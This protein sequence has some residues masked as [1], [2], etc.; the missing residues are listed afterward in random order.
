MRFATIPLITS[1]RNFQ[2]LKRHLCY[3]MATR[4]LSST[5]VSATDSRTSVRR[6]IG[7]WLPAFEAT[8]QV[9]GVRLLDGALVTE[10]PAS[11]PLLLELVQS[12]LRSGEHGAVN[13]VRPRPIFRETVNAYSKNEVGASVRSQYRLT[14]QD[15]QLTFDFY[16]E[17]SHAFIK[18]LATPS[19]F[20]Q[21]VGL[22]M[23]GTWDLV[24]GEYSDSTRVT[25]V[26]PRVRLPRILTQR[27]EDVSYVVPWENRTRLM[28][29]LRA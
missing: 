28:G 9:T 27:L 2:Q 11:A 3:R 29:L 7:C 8:L 5:T 16:V 24:R 10:G 14:V 19:K 17:D 1:A 6:C 13:L 22:T 4:C 12:V 25:V 21:P 23:L 18:T 20:V 15:A 26:G